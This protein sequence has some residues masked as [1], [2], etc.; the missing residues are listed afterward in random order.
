MA[1]IKS[2]STDAPPDAA[3]LATNEYVHLRAQPLD[4][5]EEV[6]TLIAQL[7]SLTHL[8][9]G[10]GTIEAS[11][12][13][14]LRADMQSASLQQLSIFDCPGSDTWSAGP[15]PQLESLEVNVSM[16]FKAKGFP[17]RRSP[18]ILPDKQGKLLDQVLQT[19]TCGT[20]SVQRALR[21]GFVRP[22]CLAAF[23]TAATTPC[24]LN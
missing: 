22:C 4:P 23:S 5:V 13:K 14:N 19:A 8:S 6:P 16:R 24:F 12:L 1:W 18:S 10:P 20:E 9:I 7:L 2:L 17:A 11:V 15:M 21:C 3:T